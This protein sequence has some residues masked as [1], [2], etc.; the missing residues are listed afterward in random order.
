MKNFLWWALAIVSGIVAG[1]VVALF[2]AFGYTGPGLPDESDVEA[3]K[4]VGAESWGADAPGD[5][6]SVRAVLAKLD[7]AETEAGAAPREDPV[8]GVQRDLRFDADAKD[9]RALKALDVLRANGAFEDIDRLPDS[10]PLHDG[11]GFGSDGAAV[12]TM[13]DSTLG[14]LRG[15]R[16]LGRALNRELVESISEGDDERA[17]AA[18]DRLHRLAE[19]MGHQPVLISRLVA[20]AMRQLA[21]DTV[22][23]AALRGELTGGPLADFRRSVAASD[24]GSMKAA[25]EGEIVFSRNAL[26][27]RYPGGPLVFTN[28]AAQHAPIEE[29]LR[30]VIASFDEA[31]STGMAKARDA[32]AAAN[33]R[34]GLAYPQLGVFVPA[35]A[36]AVES[37][38]T[39]ESRRR[40]LVIVL[41][42]EERRLTEGSFPVSLADLVGAQLDALPADLYGDGAYVYEV[43]PDASVPS[44]LGGCRLWSVGFDAVDNRGAKPPADARGGEADPYS[45]FASDTD[46]LFM[47]SDAAVLE[48]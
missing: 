13:L 24:I 12:E 40:A 14:D 19:V 18:F 4:E 27:A 29:T 11:W 44:A 31:P 10:H 1:V 41:A 16:Q 30:A 17:I 48:H 46:Y 2:V 34:A 42:L 7:E 43:G 9:D 35:I 20:S 26:R 37:E 21:F 8:L 25:L 47:G 28:P 33:E 45:Q 32:F 6:S 38:F 15:F 39:A 3:W 22:H 5:W 36:R 23:A